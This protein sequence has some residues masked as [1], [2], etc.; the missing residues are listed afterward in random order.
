[1]ANEIR[2]KRSLGS[3]A[4]ASLAEG[5]VAYVYGNDTM[6]IGAPGNTIVVIAGAGAFAKLAS[7]TF[8]G[9]VTTPDIKITGGTP[10]V[11]KVLTSDADGDATWETPTSGVTDHTLLSNIGTNSHAQIDSHIASNA[12]PH[13]TT[14]AQVGLSDADNTSDAAKPVS[15]AQQAALDLKAPLASPA[16]TGTPTAP[17]AANATNSTQLATT[18]FVKAVIGDL[19]NGAGTSLDTLNELAAA[20]GND[21]NFATTVT[22]SLGTKLVKTANLSDLSDAAAA[23]TNLGLGSLAT[24]A[25]G[26]VNIDGGTI[27]GVTID[28]SV[29]SGGTF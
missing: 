11:G 5:E 1:M 13:G 22:T 7:P 28:T 24:Q 3:I 20:L 8:T 21:A 23:R 25:H 15:T 4:P 12:N 6:Y 10:G 19:I 17:T 9:K 26:A 14:K 27:D 29:I 18:A 2:L 16:L